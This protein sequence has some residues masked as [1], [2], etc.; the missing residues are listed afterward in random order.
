MLYT[1]ITFK[2]SSWNMITITLFDDLV[3]A[4]GLS[5]TTNSNCDDL[6]LLIELPYIEF[7]DISLNFHK[8]RFIETTDGNSIWQICF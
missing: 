7:V 3:S 6:L 8:L 5:M 4:R 1:Y 2:Q